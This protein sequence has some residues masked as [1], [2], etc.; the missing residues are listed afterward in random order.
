MLTGKHSYLD[1]TSKQ[2]YSYAVDTNYYAFADSTIRPEDVGLPFRYT[3]IYGK[4][5]VNGGNGSK[6][7]LFGFNFKDAFKVAGVA[8]L[9]WD[10]T[11]F[12]V[13]SSSCHSI[14][15]L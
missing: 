14:A 4:L 6:L 1:Q 7:D 11:G 5:S 15:I 10:N 3:D 13:I 9:G 8:D 2:L 12:G